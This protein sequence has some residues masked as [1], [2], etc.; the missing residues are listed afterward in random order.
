MGH[1]V[2]KVGQIPARFL[3]SLNAIHE[4]KIDDIFLLGSRKTF[5]EF[6]I[7]SVSLSWKYD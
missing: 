5:I 2:K 7:V 3:L 6:N 1:S 4:T